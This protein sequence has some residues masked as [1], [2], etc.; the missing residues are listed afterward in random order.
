M[1]AETRGDAKRVK[2]EVVETHCRGDIA[3]AWCALRVLYRSKVSITIRAALRHVVQPVV[4][5][6]LSAL[7]RLALRRKY[8][9]K[10]NRAARGATG[11]S[12]GW[13]EV[14]TAKRRT[15][16]SLAPVVPRPIVDAHRNTEIFLWCQ[17]TLRNFCSRLRFSLSLVVIAPV[18][19]ISPYH[20]PALSTLAPYPSPIRRS[21]LESRAP[22]FCLSSPPPFSFLRI[23]AAQRA[24]DREAWIGAVVF[25]HEYEPAALTGGIRCISMIWTRAPPPKSSSSSRLLLSLLAVKL[26]SSRRVYTW[27]SVVP[28]PPPLP[29]VFFADGEDENGNERTDR[30][31]GACSFRSSGFSERLRLRRVCTCVFW[32]RRLSSPTKDAD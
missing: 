31:E 16:S 29:P 15:A 27:P 12:V 24:S 26:R 20:A 4:F 23:C 7:P 8:T 14:E 22:L 18:L 30:R 1:D 11:R 25:S 6:Q 21:R 13:E 5:W 2:S 17:A 3:R 19:S 28:S 9:Q 32:Y 10:D